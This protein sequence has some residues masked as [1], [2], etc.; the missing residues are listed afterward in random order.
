MLLSSQ[1]KGFRTDP[2]Y[3]KEMKINW[4]SFVIVRDKKFHVEIRVFLMTCLSEL[5]LTCLLDLVSKMFNSVSFCYNSYER[6]R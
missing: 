1:K 2:N 6:E 4:E 3:I 5:F